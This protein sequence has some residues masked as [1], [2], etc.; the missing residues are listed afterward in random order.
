MDTS[1]GTFSV[2]ETVRAP[3]VVGTGQ[4]SVQPGSGP[5]PV[6][7]CICVHNPRLPLLKLVL[8]A[9]ARQTVPPNAY[10]VII[11]DNASEPPVPEELLTPLAKRGV[12][13]FVLREPEPGL[14]RARLRAIEVTDA[15]WVLFVDDDNVLEVDFLEEGSKFIAGNPHVACFGGRLLLPPELTPGEWC[16]P[17]LSYMG[18]RD[19]GD[20]VLS[21]ISETW[22]KWEPPGAGVFVRREVLVQY[23]ELAARRPEVFSL[24]RIG[25][26]NL[27]SCDDSLLMSGA[28]KFRMATAYNPRLRLW[29]HL[30]PS[31]FRLRYLFRLM[32]AYGISH[33]TLERIQKGAVTTPPHYALPRLFRT[34]VGAFMSDR[35]QSLAYA[36]G[37]AIYHLSACREFHRQAHP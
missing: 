11:V 30:Y 28:A 25:T 16:K 37:K 3:A 18:I 4:T 12:K 10:R 22:Q 6:D 15:S 32:K 35:R 13:S 14:T 26:N 33:V 17:Y 34:L 29:H 21:G 8:S 23:R 27:A 5:G 2:S 36:L 24:G 1:L 7:V 19:L 31:R 9:L 20:V